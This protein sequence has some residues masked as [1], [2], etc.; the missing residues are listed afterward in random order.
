MIGEVGRGLE[1]HIVLVFR[2]CIDTLIALPR[3]SRDCKQ[4]IETVGNW[5]C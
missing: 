2:E 3:N 4:L 5:S 1:R